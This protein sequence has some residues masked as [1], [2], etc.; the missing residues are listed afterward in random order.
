MYFSIFVTNN[1]LDAI[2]EGWIF[3]FVCVTVTSQRWKHNFKATCEG[4]QRGRRPG[5]GRIGAAARRRPIERQR[6]RRRPQQA[7]FAFR[8]RWCPWIDRWFWQFPVRYYSGKQ[9]GVVISNHWKSYIFFVSC[10]ITNIIMICCRR[11]LWL[12]FN[13]V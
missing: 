5:G 12:F 3:P 1:Y 7:L 11:V 10:I 2:I 6:R 8:R 9:P 4:G 13:S